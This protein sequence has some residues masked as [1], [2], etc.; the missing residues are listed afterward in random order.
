MKL[1]KLLVG[2][3]VKCEKVFSNDHMTKPP[4]RY[5]EASLVQKLEKEG[6]GRP[7]TYASIISTIQDRGYVKKSGNALG[8]TFTALVVAKLLQQ[9]LPDYVDTGFTSS[10][11]GQLDE[12][13]DGELNYIDYLK[14]VYHGDNGLKQTVDRSEERIDDDTSRSIELHGFEGLSFRVGRYGAYVCRVEKDTGEEVCASLPEVAFPSDLKPAD[15]HKFIDQ[16]IKGAD[17]LGDDPE[18]GLPVFVLTGRYGPYVQLGDSAGGKEK[19]KRASIPPG[20]DSE[21]LG[22]KDALDLLRL[23][24]VLGQHPETDKDIKVGQGRFGPYVVHDGDFRS[25]PKGESLFD[26]TKERA[27]ELFAIP[28]RGRGR[29]KPL[30]ELGK[31]PQLDEPI[32]LYDGK[33]GPY[34]KVGKLNASVPD[35]VED[36]QKITLEQA[37]QW[38]E[39]KVAKATKKKAKKKKKAAKKKTTKK[40]ATKKK[41]SKKTAKKAA[42][43]TKKKKVI[44]R[45]AK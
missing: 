42:K 35:D 27:L 30:K 21:N 37:V 1:P 40:K 43:T 3:S 7:S 24:K 12:I 22:F 4:A 13:A 32:G 16:K 34:V 38:L 9:Y 17:S 29:A 15:A 10:M 44:R 20:Y 19:P 25:I 2:D 28:K 8:P 5:N 36:V 26:V 23:P 45:K 31:H 41:A 39:P 33:Y 11:E 18:T 14:Q 6:I